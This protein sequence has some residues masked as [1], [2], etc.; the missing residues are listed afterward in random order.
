MNMSAKV[1]KK[2]SAFAVAA[3]MIPDIGAPAE[4]SLEITQNPVFEQ[5]PEPFDEIETEEIW[6]TPDEVLQNAREEAA[7]IVA[8]AEKDREIIEAAAIE[9]AQQ[10]AQAAFETEITE[11]IGEIRDNFAQTIREIDGLREEISLRVEKD[12]VE[13]ALEIAKKVVGREVKFDHE[14]ALTLIKVSLKKIHSRA[15]A[16]VHLNPEDFAYVESHRQK[17]DYR[18]SLEFIEDRSISSGGCLI[19]TET[20]DVDATIES[21]F[22]EISHGLLGK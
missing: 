21:Q 16:Q 14:I 10:E 11:R 17:I 19:H 18:G 9:K 15:V 5:M 7:Q 4:T 20:G 2:D 6:T 12:V 22:A 13:L 3:F 1:F 8:Q